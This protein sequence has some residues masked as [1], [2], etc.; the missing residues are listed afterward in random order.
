MSRKK[1]QKL[2]WEQIH[3]LR[4]N[5]N[6]VGFGYDPSSIM[7]FGMLAFGIERSREKSLD[8]SRPKDGASR[9]KQFED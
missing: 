2:V 7:S 1:I 9:I 4:S 3:N 8:R 5:A 6:P